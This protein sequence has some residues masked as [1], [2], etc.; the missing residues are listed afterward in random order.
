MAYK[1]CKIY[2]KENDAYLGG[3][4][5]I[6]GDDELQFVICACCGCTIEAEEFEDD[7]NAYFTLVEIYDTWVDFSEAI[8]DESE[9]IK[10]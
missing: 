6:N 2:D 4:A 3:I 10:T 8:I 9:E 7:E 5:A 1:Q